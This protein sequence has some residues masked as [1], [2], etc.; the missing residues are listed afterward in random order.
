[1]NCE[2]LLVSFALGLARAAEEAL[3][4]GAALNRKPWLSFESAEDKAWDNEPQ[5]DRCRGQIVAKQRGIPGNR[6][7]EAHSCV[8]SRSVPGELLNWNC[9]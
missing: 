1:M 6:K 7:L 8:W 5:Q 4:N 3:I 2:E 9:N